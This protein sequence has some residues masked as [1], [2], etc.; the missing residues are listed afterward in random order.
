LTSFGALGT[1]V[2]ND[3]VWFESND[4][5]DILITD[6]FSEIHRDGVNID[7]LWDVVMYRLISYRLV[8]APST[9][10]FSEVSFIVSEVLLFI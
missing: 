5:I 7:I 3:T 2:E 10:T 1:R 9:N 4:L 8:E 6:L